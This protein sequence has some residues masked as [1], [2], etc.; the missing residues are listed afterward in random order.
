MT[1]QRAQVVS[2]SK[3]AV[4]A[5]EGSFGLGVLL[6]LPPLSLVTMLHASGGEFD[7]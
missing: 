3:W 1:L 7:S 5:G 2:I 4:T 6:G